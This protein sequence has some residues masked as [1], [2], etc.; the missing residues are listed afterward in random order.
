M[1]KAALEQ[2]A[3]R[4]GCVCTMYWLSIEGPFAPPM[5]GT[6]SG[7][8]PLAAVERQ[9]MNIIFSLLPSGSWRYDMIQS[10]VY[11]CYHDRSSADDY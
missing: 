7:R 1:M 3:K 10:Q 9:P 11:I 2:I 8:Q 4:S 6:T 5:I